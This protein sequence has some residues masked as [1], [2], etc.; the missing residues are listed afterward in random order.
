MQLVYAEGACSLAVHIMLEELGVPYEAVK[1]NL[2]EKTVLKSYNSRGYVPALVLNDGTVMTEAISILQ[3]LSATHSDAYMP[4]NT[5]EKAKCIEWLA[6]LSSELHKGLGPFFAKQIAGDQYISFAQKKLDERLKDMDQ[7]LQDHAYLVDETYSIAD[8]YA[9]A[10]LRL[11]KGLGLSLE[12][13][14]G[15]QE[16]VQSLE[17]NSVI[18]RAIE[19]EH[20]EKEATE[21][22]GLGERR[23]QAGEEAQPS[24]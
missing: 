11:V 5:E 9:L 22:R 18:K 21:V 6:F 8:M 24:M 2:H 17:Q 12:K 7:R 3:Y 10:V 23:G 20:T 16:Y 1:V 13:Y 14:R 19:K 4:K 15:V